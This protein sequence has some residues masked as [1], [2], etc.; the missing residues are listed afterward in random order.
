MPRTVEE[1]RNKVFDSDFSKRMNELSHERKARGVTLSKGSKVRSAFENYI[2][3]ANQKLRGSGVE[4]YS[5]PNWNEGVPTLGVNWSARGTRSV[6]ETK[7]FIEK[8]KLALEIIQ[9]APKAV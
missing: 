7:L 1:I 3:L 4:I 9:K 6:P 2:R 5:M 8:L